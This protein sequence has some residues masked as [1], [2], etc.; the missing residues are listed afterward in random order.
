MLS[1]FLTDRKLLTLYLTLILLKLPAVLKF[2][3]KLRQLLVYPLFSL[4]FHQIT[5]IRQ[6]YK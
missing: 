3:N 4:S 6:V 5:H 2:P 1:M